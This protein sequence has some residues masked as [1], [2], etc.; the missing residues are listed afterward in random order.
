MKKQ[1]LS[2]LKE[3]LLENNMARDVI[4]NN[5]QYYDKYISE[6]LNKGESIEDIIKELG[7]GRL[8]AKTIVEAD[9]KGAKSSYYNTASTGNTTTDYRQANNGQ[10][11]NGKNKSFLTSL[12]DKVLNIFK[13]LYNKLFKKSNNNNMKDNN[14]NNNNEYK[15]QSLFTLIMQSMSTKTKIKTILILLLSIVLIVMLAVF[16]FNIIIM[17]IPYVAILFLIGVIIRF[18]FNR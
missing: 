5:V 2:D 1:F 15:N 17:I 6:R 11:N 16:T 18:I 4:D 13:N 3:A 14:A 7:S 8:I 12:K 10:Y 9:K